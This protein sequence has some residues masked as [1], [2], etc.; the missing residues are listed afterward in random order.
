MLS[1][2]VARRGEILVIYPRHPTANLMVCA[3]K[4]G[5]P[6]LRTGHLELGA[7]YGVALMLE[8]D[9]VIQCLSPDRSLAHW[10]APRSA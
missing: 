9:G 4:P 3:N 5:Y 2:V 1:P 8:A 6:V 7:L 10:S